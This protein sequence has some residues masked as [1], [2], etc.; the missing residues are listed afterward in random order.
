MN[1]RT[2]ITF[3]LSLGLA[4]AAFN[5]A[6]A[7]SLYVTDMGHNTLT[8]YDAGTGALQQVLIPYPGYG[9]TIWMRTAAA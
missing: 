1:Q 9:A 5:F 6:S 8:K 4:V 2:R 7:D 3:T